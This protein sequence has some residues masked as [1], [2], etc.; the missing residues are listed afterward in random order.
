MLVMII[1]ITRLTLEGPFVVT[2]SKTQVIWHM[3]SKA[4]TILL[5][6]GGMGMGGVSGRN[7]VKWEEHGL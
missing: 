5:L 3:S 2:C 6:G 7:L 1:T 4:K